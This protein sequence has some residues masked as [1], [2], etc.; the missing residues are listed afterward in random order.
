MGKNAPKVWAEQ[1]HD[2][3]TASGGLAGN[4]RGG[5][6]GKGPPRPQILG[7]DGSEGRR[8]GVQ[9]KGRGTEGERG[10]MKAQGK[11]REREEEQGRRMRIQ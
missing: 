6:A 3:A 2:D 7:G 9:A 8:G 11:E 5:G 4:S 10:R 1:Y